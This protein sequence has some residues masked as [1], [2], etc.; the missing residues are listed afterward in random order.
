MF[1]KQMMSC[2]W[3]VFDRGGVALHLD[4]V[5]FAALA[6]PVRDLF[7]GYDSEVVQMVVL[8]QVAV[9][10]VEVVLQL[11]L[12]TVV[13]FL[14]CQIQQAPETFLQYTSYRF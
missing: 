12:P 9:E 7:S 11:K 8:V 3:V 10:R 13:P 6:A 14:W 5:R 1:E 4:W 2:H